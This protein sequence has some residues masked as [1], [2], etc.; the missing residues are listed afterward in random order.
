MSSV[1]PLPPTHESPLFRHRQLSPNA[2]IKVSPICLGAMSFGEAHQD[3]MGECSKETSFEILDTFTGLGGNFIDTANAYQ[4]GES[5]TRLGEW[6]NLRKNRDDLVIATKYSRPYLIHEKNRIQSNY[7]GN[8]I[9][10][11]RLSVDASLAKLQTSYIDLLYLHWWDYATSIPEIMHALNDLVVSGKVNYLGISDT[12]AWIVSKA[13]QYARD[14]G[15]RPFVVY[16]GRW[17]A[18]MRDFEREIIPMCKDEGMGIIPFGVLGQGKFQTE[19]GYKEREKENLGRKGNP[20]ERER[21]VSRVLEGLAKVKNTQITSIAL[22]YVMQ[23]APYVFPLV[24]VRKLDHI[25]GNIEALKVDLSEEDVAKIDGAYD[26]DHGFPH[27]FLSGSHFGESESK[28]PKGPGDNW[29]NKF[30]GTIDWVD[31]NPKPIK[32]FQK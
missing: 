8:N 24:G 29:L 22:A 16:Q 23:K 30:M 5:E 9:K 32:A 2:S 10:S 20:S 13:N 28:I 4:N 6:M 26:F 14:H 3:H 7:G 18:A 27:T 19:E 12:P 15:L 1:V 25:K 11:L 17:N 21:A 31:E